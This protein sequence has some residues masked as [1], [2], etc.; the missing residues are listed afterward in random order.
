M[1]LLEVDTLDGAVDALTAHN[2][3]E[4]VETCG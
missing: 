1:T 2:K 3:G 4:D